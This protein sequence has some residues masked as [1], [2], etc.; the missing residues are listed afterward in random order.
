MPV[1]QKFCAQELPEEYFS[2]DEEIDLDEPAPLLPP[3]I[4]RTK[5]ITLEPMTVREA[6][7]QV[8]QSLSD[9]S[10]TLQL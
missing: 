2:D 7:F 4:H 1:S 5:T 3:E 6:L 8:K 10:E 9:R